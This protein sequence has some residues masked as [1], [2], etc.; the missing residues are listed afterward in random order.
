M[1]SSKFFTVT[2]LLT[3]VLLLAAAYFQ[4]MEIIDYELVKSL[5]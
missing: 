1:Y 5:F 3:L 4:T 2:S